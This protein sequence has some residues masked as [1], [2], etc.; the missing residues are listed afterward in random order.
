MKFTMPSDC[1]ASPHFVHSHLIGDIESWSKDIVKLDPPVAIIV[2]G[3][4]TLR[5]VNIGTLTVRVADAQGVLRDILF[6]AMNVPGLGRH[7]FSWGGRR[8]RG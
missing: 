1:A 8:L 5:G 6:P 4:N 2:A 3:Q 7:L